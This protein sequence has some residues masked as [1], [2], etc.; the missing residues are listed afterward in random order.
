MPLTLRAE[1]PSKSTILSIC[2]PMSY[3]FGG[4][5]PPTLTKA[6]QGEL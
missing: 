6:T 2:L 3:R 5:C 4:A 1:R